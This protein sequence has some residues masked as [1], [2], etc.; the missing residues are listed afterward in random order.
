MAIPPEYAAQ[1]WG[2]AI[3]GAYPGT[4]QVFSDHSPATVAV[5]EAARAA[6]EARRS[7]PGWVGPQRTTLPGGVW[8]CA[9][10]VDAER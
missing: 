8:L 7:Q 4:R 3:C 9:Q 1:R 10:H 5:R 6:D 2:C